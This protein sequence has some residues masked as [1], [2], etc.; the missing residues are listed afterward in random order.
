MRLGRLDF[1]G[2]MILVWIEVGR[3]FSELIPESLE[4]C[5]KR[6][7]TFCYTGIS[8]D[9]DLI[10]QE[11]LNNPNLLTIYEQMRGPDDLEMDYEQRSE[12]VRRRRRRD[13]NTDCTSLCCVSTDTTPPYSY[14]RDKDGWQQ[15]ATTPEFPVRVSFFTETCTNENSPCR[16]VKS[17]DDDFQP[18]CEQIQY[19]HAI[20]VYN[21]TLGGV[22]TRYVSVPSGCR[23]KLSAKN[24]FKENNERKIGG[25]GGG[26]SSAVITTTLASN[27]AASRTT[28]AAKRRIN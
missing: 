18:Q 27:R 23:C 1:Y 11:I 8:P 19:R 7:A 25:G 5:E 15:V 24:P 26:G 3:V 28:T 22:Q 13:A 16:G 14:F 10:N 21:Q 17:T 2:L 20:L 12:Y 9:R 4:S 6:G